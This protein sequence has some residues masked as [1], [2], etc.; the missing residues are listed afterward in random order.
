MNGFRIRIGETGRMATVKIRYWAGAKAAAGTAAEEVDAATPRQA[1][2]AVGRL[3]NDP[4]FDR[5]I[6]ACSILLDGR[7]AHDADLDRP[8]TDVVELELL[9]PFAGG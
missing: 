3:R 9:P 8:V 5:V 4:S 2:A 1:L 6:G 7:A